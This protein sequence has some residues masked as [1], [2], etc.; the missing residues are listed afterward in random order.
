MADGE[1]EDAFVIPPPRRMFGFD[2]AAGVCVCAC[3]L[4]ACL[5]GASATSHPVTFVP[6]G[7]GFVAP[8]QTSHPDVIAAA[9]ADAH[10]LA[11]HGWPGDAP[12]PCVD[13]GCG[14]G[15]VVIA[16]AA[17]GMTGLG[18]DLDA[19]LLAEARTRADACVTCGAVVCGCVL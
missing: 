14:D 15:R 4:R 5:L 9:V 10:R 1:E 3:V 16:A 12:L 11:G 19:A 7:A 6:R 8:F 18:I 13:L 17:A 2:W